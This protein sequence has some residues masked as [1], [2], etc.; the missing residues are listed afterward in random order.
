MKIDDASRKRSPFEQML[1]PLVP[2]PFA[3]WSIL[4]RTGE[5]VLR[6]PPI[7][8]AQI[9]VMKQ[10]NVAAEGIPQLESLRIAPKPVEDILPSYVR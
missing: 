8:T 7:S 1:L 9:T 2:F 6:N 4:A 3:I 5:M 10:D